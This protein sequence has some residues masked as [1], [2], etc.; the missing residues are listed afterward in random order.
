MVV[1]E[2]SC[3]GPA[4]SCWA[5][6][7]GSRGARSHAGLPSAGVRLIGTSSDEV[8][9]LVEYFIRLRPV[10]INCG[11]L[12]TMCIIGASMFSSIVARYL[13]LSMIVLIHQAEVVHYD[14]TG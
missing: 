7:I 14:A 1:N 5:V 9:C 13:N 12:T 8:V 3:T 10:V 4:S 2:A 11:L 6:V